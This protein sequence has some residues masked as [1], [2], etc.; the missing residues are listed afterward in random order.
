MIGVGDDVRILDVGMVCSNTVLCDRSWNIFLLHGLQE[1]VLGW[2]NDL[3]QGISH[4]ICL[5]ERLWNKGVK[6]IV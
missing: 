1:Y 5:N 6:S 3:L 4:V 2:V